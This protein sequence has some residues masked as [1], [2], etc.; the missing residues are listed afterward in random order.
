LGLGDFVEADKTKKFENSS[1]GLDAFTRGRKSKRK[2]RE[3][4]L[5]IAQ[6]YQVAP[7]PEGIR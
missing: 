7:N 1:I 3:E 2:K 5:T 4:E 6:V